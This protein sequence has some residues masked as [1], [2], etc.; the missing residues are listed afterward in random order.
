MKKRAALV[1]VVLLAGLIIAVIGAT[2]ALRLISTS[3]VG[4]GGKPI[5]EA[6][7]RRSLAGS[8][9]PPGTGPGTGPVPTPAPGH[10]PTTSPGATGTPGS[11]GATTGV[12]PA[13]GGTVFASC[14]GGVVTLTRWI[15]EGGYGTGKSSPGPGRSAWVRFESASTELTVTATCV[16]G[17]PH[18]VTSTDD[19]GGGGGGG[20]RGGGGGGDD[21]GG[22]GRGGDGGG[23]GGRGGGH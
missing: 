10:H 15:P 1:S 4:P 9:A 3:T 20:G 13:S 21:D 19:R 2:T 8:P 12:F 11:S 7:V 17:Q 5:S 16:T 23:G 18:F 22:G 14:A 6:D